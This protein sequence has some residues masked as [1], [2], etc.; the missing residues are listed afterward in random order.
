MH[1]L[2]TQDIPPR[3]QDIRSPMVHKG[4]LLSAPS[5]RIRCHTEQGGRYSLCCR[6]RYKQQGVDWQRARRVAIAQS[7]PTRTHTRTRTHTKAQHGVPIFSNGG[8]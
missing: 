6:G 8:R 5:R 2:R 1:K 7:F 4:E 3:T